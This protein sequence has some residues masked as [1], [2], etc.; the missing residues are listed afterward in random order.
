[1]VPGQA[2][3]TEEIS[4]A[5][6]IVSA[7]PEVRAALLG[8][9]RRLGR[10]RS[11]VIEGRDIGT[12][13]FPDA[14]RKFFVTASSEVRAQRRV[15]QMSQKGVEL[16]YATTLAE[17]CARDERDRT[18]AIAPL[19]PADDAEILDSSGR[20]LP[21]MLELILDRVRRADAP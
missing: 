18:R 17:I 3:R 20:S 2:I 10:S 7:H 13:V 21:E 4:R 9:Q 8:I 14:D 5:A 19:I 11:T 12:V 16:D 15:S 6:S 1:M